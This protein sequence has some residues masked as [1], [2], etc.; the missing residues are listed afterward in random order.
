MSKEQ[1]SPQEKVLKYMENQAKTDEVQTELLRD[2]QKSLST[3]LQITPTPST[4]DSSKQEKE[5]P[6]H[7]SIADIDKDCPDCKKNIETMTKN[8]LAERRT[9][10]LVCKTC[11]VGVDKEEG[12]CPNCGGKDAI[13][14]A[15][16]RNR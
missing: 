9:K 16:F 12:E 6:K 5:T 4:S 15:K 1:E 8:N 14:R 10:P 3:K 7:W 2:I 13:E 11:G